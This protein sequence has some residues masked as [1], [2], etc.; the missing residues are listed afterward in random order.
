L[1]V[2]EDLQLEPQN[3]AAYGL[4]ELK[5]GR[6]S[7][8]MGQDD[9]TKHALRELTGR[10]S[11]STAA[12][13]DCPYKHSEARQEPMGQRFLAGASDSKGGKIGS[14]ESRREHPGSDVR[15]ALTR[16]VLPEVRPGREDDSTGDEDG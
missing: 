10:A 3:T 6:A 1:T 14:L 12:P 7:V 8:S 5:V 9:A 4:S 15:I 11:E 16:G 13:D 2:Q